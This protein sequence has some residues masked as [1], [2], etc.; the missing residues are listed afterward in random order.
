MRK[1]FYNTRII[2]ID[3][4]AKNVRHSRSVSGA[5]GDTCT[6]HIAILEIDNQAIEISLI[7]SIHINDGDHILVAGKHRR[8][9]LHGLAYFNKTK[10]VK[11]KGPL[12]LYLIQ[13][14]VLLILPPIGIYFLY[15]TDQYHKAYKIIDT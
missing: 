3:G 10:N 8:G 14:I 1:G 7:E 2:K 13:G 5:D 4:I 9:V 11:G 12:V 15:R 6:R